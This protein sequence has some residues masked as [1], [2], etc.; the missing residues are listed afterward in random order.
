MVIATLA[1]VAA[2]VLAFRGRLGEMSVERTDYVPLDLGPVSATDVALL[3]PPTSL[4]GYNV[5][6]TD[7]AMEQIAE[8]IRERDVRIVA[9]EQLVTDLGREHAPMTPLGSPYEGARHRRAPAD[10]VAD[11]ATM[12]WQG[13]EPAWQAPEQSWEGHEPSWQQQEQPWEQGQEEPWQQNQEQPWQQDQGQH[14]EQA[15]EPPWQ[16]PEPPWQAPDPG[17][18]G[19][20]QA[21]PPER[22]HD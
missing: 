18:A 10:G 19:D 8:S 15:Q 7:E 21:P 2:A 4:W 3:R 20:D 12:R 9:L 5:Q 14:W 6:A 1:V 16:S 22:S 11:T 17:S 13:T